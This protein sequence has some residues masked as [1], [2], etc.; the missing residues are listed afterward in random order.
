M[1]ACGFGSEAGVSHLPPPLVGTLCEL[2]RWRVGCQARS[3]TFEPHSEVWSGLFPVLDV[4]FFLC[5]TGVWTDDS[6]GPSVT[7]WLRAFIARV[8][9]K[10]RLSGVPQDFEG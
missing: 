2:V 8:S 3:L 4:T 5:G 10:K 6:P 7:W 1:V 9:W